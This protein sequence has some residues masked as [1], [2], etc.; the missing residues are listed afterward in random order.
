MRR[1]HRN[2]SG[3]ALTATA[4]QDFFRTSGHLALGSSAAAFSNAA[5]ATKLQQYTQ[6]N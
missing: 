4:C 6:H 2:I 5:S 3:A 1:G